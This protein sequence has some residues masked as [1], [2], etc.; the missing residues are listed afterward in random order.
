MGVPTGEIEA[1]AIA[2]LRGDSTLQ[3]MLGN[4]VNP[5]G[6][7]F[8]ANGLAVNQ[9]A[10]Y[11]GVFLPTNMKGTAKAFGSDSVDTI[12]QVSIF[13]NVGG[14]DA[15]FEQARGIAKQTYALLQEQ[16]LVLTGGFRNFFI[17]FQN[18]QEAPEPD[19][20]TQQIAQRYLLKTQG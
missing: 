3:G 18:Q 11:I 20:L 19:G 4:P 15:G 5:P 6:S 14:V 13:T 10:P 17:Q 8:D 12:M 9:A 2:R 7:V 1:A 16:S